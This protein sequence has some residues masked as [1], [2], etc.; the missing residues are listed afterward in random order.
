MRRCTG[1]G[2]VRL[3]AEELAGTIVRLYSG[4]HRSGRSRHGGESAEGVVYFFVPLIRVPP[5][6][7]TSGFWLPILSLTRNPFIGT[8]LGKLLKSRFRR[9]MNWAEKR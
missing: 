4:L 6:T 1:R 8:D 9:K 2:N 7:T 5:F 3:K